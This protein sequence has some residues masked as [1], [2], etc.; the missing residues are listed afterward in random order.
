MMTTADPTPLPSNLS[1]IDPLRPAV[2]LD[3]D[4]TI[5]ACDHI[6]AHGD[7]GYPELVELLPGV[8][9]ALRSLSEAGF[10]L[11]VATNQGG[12]ARGRY[13]VDAVEA[14]HERVNELLG[15]LITAFRYCPYHPLGTVEAYTREHPW[16]KP[17]PGMLLDAASEYGLELANSWMVGDKL[18]DCE[19]G[20]GAGCRTVMIGEQAG[21]HDGEDCV[22]FVARDL[23]VAARI[24]LERSSGD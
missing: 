9:E 13:G 24:I 6:V 23:P 8:E 10:V 18:R 12:V 14:V 2:F 21:K 17:Q 16:R 19:A 5:I 15:G 3:R 1:P 7:M 4:D 11:V 22:D 20:R